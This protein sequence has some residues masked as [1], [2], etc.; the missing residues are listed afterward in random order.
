M[1]LLIV[2][3]ISVITQCKN[4]TDTASALQEQN[5]FIYSNVQ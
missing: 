2:V 1:P 3:I 5:N 4:P